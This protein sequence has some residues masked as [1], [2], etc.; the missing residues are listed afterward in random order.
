[1]IS[2]SGKPTYLSPEQQT[3]TMNRDKHPGQSV[4]NQHNLQS[5]I[6]AALKQQE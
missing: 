2:C 4:R 6:T 3:K 5:Q 1:M